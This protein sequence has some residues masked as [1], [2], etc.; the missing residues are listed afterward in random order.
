MVS[1]SSP[2]T[3]RR[4]LSTPELAACRLCSP[5]SASALSISSSPGPPSGQ[6][7][8]TAAAPYSFSPSRKWPGHSLPL[9][10]ASSSPQDPTRISVSSPSSSSSSQPSTHLAR[11]PCPSP[12]APKSS[13]Y[14]TAKSACPGPWQPASSGPPSS[15]SPSLAFSAPFT[16][17]ALS[18]STPA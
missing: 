1:T 9:G 11:V 18:A 13:P 3:P 8:P 14:P 4:S 2:S 7:T 16:P 12:T 6:S 15:A 17:S 5:P 10:S